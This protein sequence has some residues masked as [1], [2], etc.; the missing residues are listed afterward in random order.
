[1]PLRLMQGVKKGIMEV[2]DLVVVNKA[3]GDLKAYARAL[4]ARR[5]VLVV[6]AHANLLACCSLCEQLCHACPGGHSACTAAVPPQVAP[7][8]A[9]SPEV[10][11]AGRGRSRCSVECGVGLQEYHD[12]GEPGALL[13]RE[14]NAVQQPLVWL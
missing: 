9:A 6:H 4:A 1:M 11:L 10:Q 8:D 5:C 13:P 2:V 12:K 14:H 7:V 3:D